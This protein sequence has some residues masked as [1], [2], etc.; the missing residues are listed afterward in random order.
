M[1]KIVSQKVPPLIQQVRFH[2]RIERVVD[3]HL[4]GEWIVGRPEPLEADEESSP[5]KV[6][7]QFTGN[8]PHVKDMLEDFLQSQRSPAEEV[9]FIARNGTF[10]FPG[11][12]WLPV[13]DALESDLP[14]EVRNEVRTL[15]LRE[16]A[17]V[18][19]L[20]E[21]DLWLE[22]ELLRCLALIGGALASRKYSQLDALE[23]EAN[24]ILKRLPRRHFVTNRDKRKH[25]KSAKA[26][27]KAVAAVTA[28]SIPAP[29]GTVAPRPALPLS[30]ALKG[31]GNDL[32]DLGFRRAFEDV[33]LDFRSS[34]DEGPGLEITV[35]SVREVLY[36]FLL[37]NLT[38]GWRKCKR[39]DCPKIFA[40]GYKKEQVYCS[41][42]CA[43]LEYMRR[44]RGTKKRR[45]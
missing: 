28:D 6:A 19:L 4:V 40:V 41:W 34:L 12:D 7:M 38:R 11:R 27:A 22:K 42:A 45:K 3:P 5:L 24:D 30:Q 20:R 8:E 25:A 18:Y 1:V 43:H 9:R 23:N 31:K 13:K 14:Q 17:F 2:A 37:A 32:L 15:K 16:G 39:P 10:R 33:R 36:L 29:P 21:E 44:V 35:S 26:W